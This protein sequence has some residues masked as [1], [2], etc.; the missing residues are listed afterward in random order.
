MSWGVTAGWLAVAGTAVLTFGTGAQAWASLAEYKNLRQKVPKAA[1]EALNQAV[2]SVAPSG[3]P[4]AIVA[5][6]FSLVLLLFLPGRLARIEE[7]SDD[8][9]QL[10]RFLRL[11]EVWGILMIGSALTLAAAVIQLALA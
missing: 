4:G 3:L 7:G 1:V 5:I 2:D 10:G 11:A 8:A 6:L 9:I